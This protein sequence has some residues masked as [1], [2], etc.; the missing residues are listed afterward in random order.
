MQLVDLKA[1]HST[2]D[3][4]DFVCISIIYI[5]IVYWILDIRLDIRDWISDI[6]QIQIQ[7]YVNV[8]VDVDID[9]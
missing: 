4:T 1:L 6:I 8:G 3:V 7:I 5:Y 9:M 2:Q